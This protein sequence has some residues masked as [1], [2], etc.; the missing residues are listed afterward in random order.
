M[1]STHS[2]NGN[3]EMKWSSTLASAKLF[4]SPTN[5]SII[6]TYIIHGI[7]LQKCD[8]V[9]YLGVTIDSNL[10]WKEHCTSVCNKASFMMSFFEIFFFYK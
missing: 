6:H 1:T 9:M 7:N 4:L 10:N 3:V 5:K 2:K 8:S